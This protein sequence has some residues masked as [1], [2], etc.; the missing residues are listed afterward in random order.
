MN[1]G[2]GVTIAIIL[3]M[4]F[5]VSFVVRAFNR[6]SDLVS[7]TY[8]EEGLEYEDKVE[9]QNNYTLLATSIT[10]NKIPEGI[11]IKFPQDISN[12]QNGIIKFY[13]P[14][15]KKY[16]RSFD[17]DLSEENTQIL[18]YNNFFEGFYELSIAWDSNNKSY[19]F[20]EDI[21]F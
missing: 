18:D 7:D 6:D 10:I 17:L 12:P 1:W 15:S 11:E 21:T 16:D 9:S 14:Q 5:I 8:Y 2:K 13:R 20:E 19:L 4:G 3:F